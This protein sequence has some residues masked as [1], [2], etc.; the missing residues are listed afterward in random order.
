MPEWRLS[1]SERALFDWPMPRPSEPHPDLVAST[2]A[3]DH[4]AQIL[5]EL[6]GC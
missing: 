6:F 1:V 5:S 4:V 2:V 3:T